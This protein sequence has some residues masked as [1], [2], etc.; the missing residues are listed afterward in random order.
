MND[1]AF[2]FEEFPSWQDA[3]INET[4]GDRLTRR[5]RRVG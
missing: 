1:A 3:R 5:D 4:G 2:S